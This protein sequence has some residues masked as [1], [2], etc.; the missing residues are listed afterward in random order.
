MYI[1]NIMQTVW[2]RTL[3]PLCKK[4]AVVSD[5]YS[6]SAANFG[7]VTSNTNFHNSINLGRQFDGIRIRCPVHHIVLLSL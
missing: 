7:P 1:L 6:A 3:F 5:V 2:K 4:L